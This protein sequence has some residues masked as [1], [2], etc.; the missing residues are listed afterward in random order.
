MSR[1]H[2]AVRSVIV[3]TLVTLT[4]QG[5]APAIGLASPE[6]P[7]PPTT[8]GRGGPDVNGDGY[9]DLVIGVPG[10]GNLI[11]ALTVVLGR[12]GGP[13]GRESALWSQESAGVEGS[14]GGAFG[15]THTFGDFDA[16]GYD[17]LAI[18]VPYDSDSH[19]LDSGAVNILY[20]SADG[21]TA[22]DDQRWSQASPG[23]EGEP[24]GAEEFG[25]ALAA[26]D[27]NSDGFTDLAV[28]LV[29]DD[30]RFVPAIHVL[31]GSAAGLSADGSAYWKWPEGGND[32]RSPDDGLA[33]SAGD[34]DADGVD[35][36]AWGI[37][38]HK[39]DQGGVHVLL[40]TA[41][42]L[43]LA[44]GPPLS[45]STEGVSGREHDGEEFGAALAS[46]DF[47]GDGF[48]DLAVATPF[49][50]VGPG[51]GM[52]RTVQVFT[53]SE[54][55][56]TTDSQRFDQRELRVKHQ[57][58]FEGGDLSLTAG[59]LNGDDIAEL[60]VGFPTADVTAD[61]TVVTLAGVVAVLPGSSTGL[62]VA[63][64]V[65][66]DQESRG[67]RETSTSYDAFGRSGSIADLDGDGYGDLAIGVPAEDVLEYD[68]AGAANVVFGSVD[69]LTG[70]GSQLWSQSK[71]F[72]ENL[73]ASYESF[74]VM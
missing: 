7:L 73:T 5:A 40:G 15:A 39:R 34:Y 37:P 6:R 62:L 14:G 18:G 31:Y 66:W 58:G 1:V 49:D 53:G 42:G 45:Q 17:D 32:G 16:D 41:T 10:E 28:A 4:L 8:D 26:G 65:R 22:D 67:I 61:G 27:F 74:G 63:E 30:R 25:S 44:P 20:G 51:D 23:I 3:A 24:G 12:A 59:D 56:L 2:V 68:Y 50:R 38:T 47:D 55:G 60:A 57:P 36:L 70:V 35:D 43:V 33:L 11:G 54:L 29:R 72:V 52:A 21:T 64:A 13:I 46:A 19:S 71:R 48:T 69:G 9:D